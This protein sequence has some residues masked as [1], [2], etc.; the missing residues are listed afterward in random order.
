MKYIIKNFEKL[1]NLL[2]KARV[3]DSINYQKM[4]RI[5][6]LYIQDLV[7]HVLTKMSKMTN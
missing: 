3:T 5:E 7:F 1:L 6:S 4:G 2:A